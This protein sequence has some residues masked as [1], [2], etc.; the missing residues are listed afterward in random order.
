MS[1]ADTLRN[2]FHPN[3]N[4]SVIAESEENA[5][6]QPL[7]DAQIDIVA[8]EITAFAHLCA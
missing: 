3:F 1:G 4:S 2:R 7:N 5:E 6:T 8:D